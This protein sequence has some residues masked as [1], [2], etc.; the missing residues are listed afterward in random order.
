MFVCVCLFCV[1]D[2][3][4]LW[5]GGSSNVAFS[6]FELVHGG[7]GWLWFV[8]LWCLVLLLNVCRRSGDVGSVGEADRCDDDHVDGDEC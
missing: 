3:A 4:V 2:L 8:S 1:F 5:Q 7:C 6:L